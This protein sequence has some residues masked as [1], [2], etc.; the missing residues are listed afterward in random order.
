MLF[1]HS[2]MLT[3]DYGIIDQ[4]NS[5][6]LINLVALL[7]LPFMGGMAGFFL[8]VSSMGNMIS[9]QRHLQAGK[10]VKSL[11]IR[12]VLGGI[13]L[14]IF[15]VLTEA[16]IGY[17]G[18][19]GEAILLKEDWLM[20]GLT[21]GYH[22]ETI[23]TIAWC[24]I[25]NGLVHAALARNEKW[26]DVDRNIK[27][28]VVLAILI[29]VLTLP[30]WLAVDSLIPGYPYATYSDIGRANSNL[31]IQYPFPGVSTFWEYI[32]L[33]PLAA[34]AGQP[35][36]IFPYLAISFVGS[37]FGIYLSQERDKIP[38]DFPKR[39]MQVGF[40][41][42]FIGLIGL[43]VTYVDLLINQSLDV[44]LTTYLRLWDHRSYT[45]DGP[46]NTHWFGWLFQLLCLNGASIWATLFIIYMVEY[47]GKGAIF[48]KK[49]QPIRRYGFVAFTVYNNQ[50]IIFFGQL[51]VSLLFGLTVYSKFGWGGVFLVMLLTYLIFEIILRLWEKV[52]YVGTLEWCM[53]TIGSFMIPAR[54]Q[55]VSEESGEIP[56]WWK[57]GTPKVQKAFYNVD[58]LNVVLPSEINHKQKKES[59]LAW[60]LSLVGL[61]LF[62]LSIVALNIA[63]NSTELEG[64]NPYN[65]RAKILSLVSLIFTAIWITLAIIFTP[66]MLGIPL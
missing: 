24:I 38:R 29:V 59:R 51:I 58:W 47:R 49:T 5:L 22:M 3:L 9:M 31:T 12:Q 37:I 48:A 1:L 34:I 39:G 44:T 8:L 11:A 2:I 4:I 25:I 54:K 65:S 13:I 41:L 21:R 46:G 18:A 33:F 35:E 7:L 20:T 55:M 30:I 10:P 64:K 42:F 15:A 66:N 23:H 36:P 28:Y 60:K 53:G 32:Y 40:I 61:L 16:W 6:P 52:D 14:L 57:M 50:W 56:K 17:H 43:I 19:L 27:I 62:P 45:P 26:K 63:K